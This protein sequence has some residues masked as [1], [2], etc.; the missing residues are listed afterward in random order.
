MAI[1]LTPN[2]ETRLRQ[3]AA[4]TGQAA[5][6]LAE[7]LLSDALLGEVSAE[8]LRAEYQQLTASE[9]QGTLSKAMAFRLEEV[10]QEMDALD[11]NSPQNL[12]EML[13]IRRGLPLAEAAR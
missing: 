6:T 7:S 3:K 5:D 10:T 4:R 1:T 12:D 11:M 13:A 9:M 2:I 8:E